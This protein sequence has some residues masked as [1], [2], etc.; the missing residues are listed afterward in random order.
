MKIVRASCFLALFLSGHVLA[1]E[2]TPPPPPPVAPEAVA[3]IAEPPPVETQAWSQRCLSRPTGYYGAHFWVPQPVVVVS[4]P[5]AVAGS[6]HGAQPVGTAGHGSSSSGGSGG[7]GNAGVLLLAAAVVVA[8]ALPF[9]FYALDDDAAPDVVGRFECPSFE[10]DVRG[11]L[12]TDARSGPSA[13]LTVRLKA[14]TAWLGVMAQFDL[15]PWSEPRPLLDATV[16]A[17]VRFTPRQH[18]EFGLSVGYR[19]LVLRDEWRPGFEAALPHEYLFF[20]D[21]ASHLGLEVRPAVFVWSRGADLSLD[22]ALRLPLGQVFSA[23]LGGRVFSVD[24]LTQLGAGVQGGLGLK[25]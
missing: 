2:L 25:L 17:V 6:T 8:V 9:I 13:P 4:E 20:R 1:Q 15:A 24:A 10:L 14:S 5:A 11:G 3:P 19:S 16:A 21:G 22:V 12:E 7:V 23:S 18:V